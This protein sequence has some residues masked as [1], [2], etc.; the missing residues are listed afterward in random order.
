MT[1]YRIYP[2]NFKDFVEIS[3]NKENVSQHSPFA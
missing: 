2:Q 1:I 3:K